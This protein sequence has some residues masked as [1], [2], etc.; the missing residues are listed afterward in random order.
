MTQSDY[1]KVKDPGFFKENV[2]PAHAAFNLYANEA[3][4]VWGESSL[5]QPLDGIWK[6]SYHNHYIRSICHCLCL[7]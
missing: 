2:L 1:N 3:E 7:C 4:A 5:K 6:F